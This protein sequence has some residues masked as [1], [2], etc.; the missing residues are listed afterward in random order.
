MDYM[1][2]L[3]SKLLL[4]LAILILVS[5]ANKKE[6]E[7]L[8]TDPN[9]LFNQASNDLNKGKYDLAA[10]S[11]A[12]IYV[13]HPYSELATK[14][15]L[16]EA[17]SWYEKQDFDMTL[18]ILDEFVKLHPA[19]KDIDYAY[20]L[21][22]MSYYYQ[23]SDSK[24][25]QEQTLLSK[26]AIGEVIARFP[27][28]NYAREL[29]FKLDLVNDHLAGNEMEIARFYQARNDFIAAINRYDKVIKEYQTTNHVKEALARLVECYLALGI[30]DEATKY[31][32]ILGANY[33]ASSWYQYSY[34]LLN[35]NK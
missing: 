28:S 25:D 35:K 5:C 3:L 21:R 24:H 19:Y 9:I 8:P 12:K 20:Y 33:P 10:E 11:F 23:I 30:V 31:A 34:D 2:N 27:N 6:E 22:A 32:S 18:A 4:C 1:K 16:M 15:K 7:E 17:Y 13:E 29:K 14:A 26:N